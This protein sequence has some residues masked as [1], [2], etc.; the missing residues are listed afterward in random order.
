MST[1]FLTGYSNALVVCLLREGLVEVRPGSEG[2][3]VAFVATYLHEK[4]RGGSIISS[5]SAALLACP[6]VEELY[7]DDDQLKDVVDGLAYGA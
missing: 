4:A 6:D 3:V 7:A 5:T 1:P 2:Q